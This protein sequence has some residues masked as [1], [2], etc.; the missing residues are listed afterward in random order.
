MEST[1]YRRHLR[2][3]TF[4]VATTVPVFS[5]NI[6]SGVLSHISL[7]AYSRLGVGGVARFFVIVKTTKQLAR[8]MDW[9]ITQDH[10]L[11]RVHFIGEGTNTFFADGFFNGLIVV[12][13]IGGI[14]DCGDGH[15]LV[16]AGVSMRRVVL[17]ALRRRYGGLA[18]ARGLPGSV[19]GAVRGNAGAFGGQMENCVSRVE[20]ISF[21]PTSF[22]ASWR[23]KRSCR[24]GYRASAFKEQHKKRLLVITRVLFSLTPNASIAQEITYAR[25]CRAYRLKH[26]P[27]RYPTLGSTFKNVPLSA[28]SSTV[29]AR[30]THCIKKDPFPL[31]PVAALLDAAGLKGARVNGVMLSSQHPNFLIRTRAATARDVTRLIAYARRVIQKKFSITLEEEIEYVARR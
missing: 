3:G 7:S 22:V 1:G 31:I 12:V 26:H 29:R 14:V 28:V 10:L 17:Y 8:V 25:A 11:S 20:S 2:S 23:S 13:R 27:M 9:W 16:G 6:P 19:G 21:S 15:L 30:F 5:M 24:F 18:W 4:V